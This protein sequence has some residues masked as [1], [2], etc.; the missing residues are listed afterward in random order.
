MFRDYL[1]IRKDPIRFLSEVE[2]QSGGFARL[3]LLLF[4]YYYV[5][6]PELIREALIDRSET[7]VIQ[8]GASAGLARLIGHGIL[9]NR[10]ESWRKSRKELQPLFQKDRLD[11][12]LPLIR[13]R[14]TEMLARWKAEL[15][16]AS[17]ALNR[18][19]LALSFRIKA[20]SLFGYLPG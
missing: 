5:G 1:S 16:G 6:D 14:V 2:R 10:G 3:R 19:L 7:F 12:Y 18:E 17:F 9:T 11:S 4:P 13:A 8:G 15:S 20:S